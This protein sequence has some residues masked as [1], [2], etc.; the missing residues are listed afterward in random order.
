[1][2]WVDCSQKESRS[3]M[4][5]NRR[6]SIATTYVIVDDFISSG[7]TVKRI[8]R[9]LRKHDYAQY[10][11]LVGV[12][13]YSPPPAFRMRGRLHL[14]GKVKGDPWVRKTLNTV[15]DKYGVK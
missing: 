15:F 13:E 14:P 12:Y 1:M 9:Q 11:E 7:A 2:R 6:R 10:A 8:A 3:F 4:L 5:S